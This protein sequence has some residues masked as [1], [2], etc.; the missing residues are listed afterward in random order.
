MAE[1][2]VEMRKRAAEVEEER[3]RERETEED[4]GWDLRW[5]S[6]LRKSA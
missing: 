4:E 3:E 2:R 1:R 5:S 6:R